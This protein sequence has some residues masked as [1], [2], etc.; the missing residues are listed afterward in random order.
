MEILNAPVIPYKNLSVGDHDFEFEVGKGFF[1]KFENSPVG[2]GTAKVI[3]AAHKGAS[4]MKLQVRIEARAEVL[5]D[6]C[7]EP[8]TIPV[9]YE[10]SLEVHQDDAQAGEYDGETLWVS[11]RE[12]GVDLTQYVYES[13]CIALPLQ[14]VHGV[15]A[16]GVSLC[17]PDMLAR[18][19]I[20][21]EQEFDALEQ[22]ESPLQR[23]LEKLKDK[24]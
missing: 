17:D 8:L 3:V 7:L 20:V 11:S 1:E 23:E 12:E 15:D 6:R 13:V 5:C 21:S 24:K 18:F 22:K 10:G 9:N 16:N 14:R 2:S 4:S 19:Q